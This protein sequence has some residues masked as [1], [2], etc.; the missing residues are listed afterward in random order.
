MGSA[1]DIVNH[2]NKINSLFHDAGRGLPDFLMRQL[3]TLEEADFKDYMRRLLLA[4]KYVPKMYAY[5][6]QYFLKSLEWLPSVTEF[7]LFAS[8]IGIVYI[9]V[10]ILHNNYINN[11]VQQQSRCASSKQKDDTSV[12]VIDANGVQLYTV[13][14]DKNKSPAQVTCEGSGAGDTTN[15]YNVTVYDYDHKGP[16]VIQKTCAQQTAVAA[17]STASTANANLFY[18]GTRGIVDFMTT[19]NASY[20]MSN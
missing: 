10:E 4:N 2:Y 11:K 19:N 13:K 15:T 3:S 17:G 7:I 1:V 5:T 6:A 20:F 8:F 12:T 9:I 14:Y 18:S 16:K